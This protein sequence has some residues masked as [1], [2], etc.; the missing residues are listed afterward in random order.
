VGVLGEAI[1]HREDDR[2]AAHLRHPS[3]NSMEMSAHTWDGTW[4]GCSSPV[5]CRVFVLF[6]WH[7]VHIQT[8]SATKVRSPGT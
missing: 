3:M 5:G 8:Q 4:R 2:F 1:D 7:V 6:C